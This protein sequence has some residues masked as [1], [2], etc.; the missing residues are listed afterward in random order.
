MRS[1]DRRK[2]FVRASRSQIK[3]GLKDTMIGWPAHAFLA[4]SHSRRSMAT[5]S[6]SVCFFSRCVLSM[7]IKD[8]SSSK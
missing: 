1:F 3:V 7:T 4:S 6:R 8:E 2:R 5:T